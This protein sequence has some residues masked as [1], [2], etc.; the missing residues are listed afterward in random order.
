MTDIPQRIETH[1]APRPGGHYSQAMVANGF[2]FL[3]GQLPIHHDG[4]IH[5]H[6]SFDVQAR[7]AID[8]ML[9]IARAAG[10]DPEHLVKVT[11]FIVGIDNWRHFNAI[12]DE[13]LG[14]ARPARTVVPVL[15]LHHGCLVEI[16]AIGA[17]V[18]GG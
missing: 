14:Y 2:V 7:I 6:E 16:E 17:I 4:T 3:S 18:P 8:N 9:A 15:E 12:Y 5:R 10:C 13:M 1:E 11:A